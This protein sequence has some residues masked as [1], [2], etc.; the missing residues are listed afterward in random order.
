MVLTLFFLVSFKSYHA[1]LAL[2]LQH[3]EGLST[4]HPVDCFPIAEIMRT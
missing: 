4:P 3:G 2:F 1:M